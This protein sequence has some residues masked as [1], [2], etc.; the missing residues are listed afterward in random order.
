MDDKSDKKAPEHICR[1]I[2]HRPDLYGEYLFVSL[3]Q[4]HGTEGLQQLLQLI[5][6]RIPNFDMVYGIEFEKLRGVA[7]KAPELEDQQKL[8]RFFDKHPEA[9]V[10]SGHVHPKILGSRR[11]DGAQRL[12]YPFHE[13]QNMGDYFLVEHG[14]RH[15]VSMYASNYTK[16]TMTEKL[17]RCFEVPGGIMVMLIYSPDGPIINKVPA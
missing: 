6:S 9:P 3:D 13:L 12:R 17:I 15:T 14:N 10:M 5:D 16:Y 4:Y 1:V 2:Q 8:L 11:K 7:F